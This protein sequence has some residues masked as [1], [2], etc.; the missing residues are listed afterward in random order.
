MW[1]MVEA[2]NNQQ[3]LS[4]SPAERPLSLVERLAALFRSQPNEW[5][6]GRVLARTAGY[7]AWR[8]RV[9]DLRRQPFAMTMVN[10]QR[11]VRVDGRHFTISEYKFVVSEDQTEKGAASGAGT[12]PAAV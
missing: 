6:D 3:N 1:L 12:S 2:M 11:H 10:R 4:Q 5:I 8:T 7:A 9:S